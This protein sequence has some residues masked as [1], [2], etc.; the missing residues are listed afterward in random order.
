VIDKSSLGQRRECAT[1]RKADWQKKGIFGVH[2]ERK[3]LGSL[4]AR[5]K[6]GSSEEEEEEEDPVVVAL[7]GDAGSPSPLAVPGA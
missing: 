2:G 6:A 3:G 7:S 5:L 1:R 4:G